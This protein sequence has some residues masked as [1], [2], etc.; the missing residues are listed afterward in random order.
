[1]PVACQ[2]LRLEALAQ[3]IAEVGAA[4]LHQAFSRKFL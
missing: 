3:P 4:N 2:I 1:M